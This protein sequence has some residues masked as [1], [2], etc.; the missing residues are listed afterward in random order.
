M[1]SDALGHRRRGGGTGATYRRNGNGPHWGELAEAE[2]QVEN[3]LPRLRNLLDEAATGVGVL[4]GIYPHRG[5]AE[6]IHP[7][8]VI[9]QQGTA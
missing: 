5:D 6:N 8:D 9:A 3:M 1:A 7:V 2:P 4:V